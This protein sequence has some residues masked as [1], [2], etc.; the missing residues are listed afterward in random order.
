MGSVQF[1]HGGGGDMRSFMM[2]AGSQDIE[3]IIY[4][5]PF[6]TMEVGVVLDDQPRMMTINTLISKNI[7]NSITSMM[8]TLE[9]NRSAEPFTGQNIIENY[10][11]NQNPDEIIVDNEDPGF[12]TH[13]EITESFLKK[14][15]NISTESEEKYPGISAWRPPIEWQATTNSLFYGKFIRSALYAKAGSG[16]NKVSWTANISEAGNYDIFTYIEPRVTRMSRMS[17]MGRGRGNRES[18]N[19]SSR[20][21]GLEQ[22]EN[23]YHY[24]IYH[25]DGIENAILDVSNAEQGWNF[26]G[27][28]YISSGSAKVELSNESS[29]TIVIADAIK[30]TRR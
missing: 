17:R 25:D 30:W 7:P 6:Q 8:G 24:Q 11:G 2:S 29:A 28:F 14:L 15:L 5:E 12:E 20:T 27:T 4:F 19:E 22:S 16:Q 13:I 23:Q 26:L 10:T 9:L 1:Q 21:G 18:R 3:R